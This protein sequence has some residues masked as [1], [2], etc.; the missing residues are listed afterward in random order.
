MA[1]PEQRA[2]GDDAIAGAQLTRERRKYRGHTAGRRLARFRTFDQ[3][4]ALFEHAH[5]RIAVARID[6]APAAT[7][8]QECRLGFL[9]RAIDEAGGEEHRLG[10][11]VHVRAAQS[12]AYR[13]GPRT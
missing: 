6:E 10:S 13:L 1:R 2:A 3:A 11:L 4:Q 7:A 8:G 12:A 9:G 5:G